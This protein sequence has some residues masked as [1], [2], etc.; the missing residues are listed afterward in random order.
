MARRRRQ[1]AEARQ[2]IAAI[3]RAAADALNANPAASME[4][5]A[6]TAGV[7]RQTV[8]AHFPSREAL[9]DAVTQRATAEVAAALDEAGLDDAPPAA[10]LSRLLD[11][12][13][14]VAARYPLLWHLPP[15]ST[16]QDRDRHAPVLDRMLAIIERG[17]H[18]GDFDR[19]LSPRWLLA[20]ALALGRAADDEVRAGRMTAGEATRAVQ[21]SFLRLFGMSGPRPAED[22][23]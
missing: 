6:R 4:D 12:G 7:S 22:H 23:G 15:V 18:T 2:S 21:H 9:L 20:A 5:I 3:L 11:T 1:R 14:Q 10:A 13:W 17:Q 8:Y 16:D 19:E